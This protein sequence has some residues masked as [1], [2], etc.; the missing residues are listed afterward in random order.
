[1]ILKAFESRQREECYKDYAETG[2]PRDYLVERAKA[3]LKARRHR[4]RYLP[5][6]M[7]GEPAWDMLIALYLAEEETRPETICSLIVGA[8]LPHATGLR[9]LHVMEN[10]RLA[11]RQ[12]HPSDKR[13]VQMELTENGRRAL[14]NYFATIASA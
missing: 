14:D 13:V 12:P 7:F 5:S 1:M 4:H 9:W 6:S 11:I 2:R 8:G 10:H 3:E